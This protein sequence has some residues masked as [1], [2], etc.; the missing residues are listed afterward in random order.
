MSDDVMASTPDTELSGTQLPL[1]LRWH[2][3]VLQ[4]LDQTRLPLEETVI[5]CRDIEKVFECIASL[6]VRGAP[7]IGVAA[8]YGLI[9]GLT[10]RVNIDTLER[11]GQYLISARPTAVNLP[12]AINRMLEIARK[13]SESEIDVSVL[14]AEA[15]LIHREDIKA[16]RAIG[17]FGLPIVRQN[18]RLLTHCNA[19]AL[20]VSESGTA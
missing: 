15:R 9:V 19:G 7:A 5:H 16:C 6:R 12:W 17:Q 10:S 4:L 20:A 13:Q 8:A 18:P 2:D 3:G 1:S 11:R 14:E